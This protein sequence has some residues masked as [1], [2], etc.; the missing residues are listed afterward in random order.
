LASAHSRRT[1]QPPWR[2]TIVDLMDAAGM[3]GSA[4]LMVADRAGIG[5]LQQRMKELSKQGV[6]IGTL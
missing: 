3:D 5:R 4:W 1:V 2:G 6:P